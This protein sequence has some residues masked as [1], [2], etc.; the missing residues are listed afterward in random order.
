MHVCIVT[1]HSYVVCIIAIIVIIIG[2]CYVVYHVTMPEVS[3]CLVHYTKYPN[4]PPHAP[5]VTAENGSCNPIPL[6]SPSCPPFCLM[7]GASKP[8]YSFC[9][10]HPPPSFADYLPS[11]SP[12]LLFLYFP[13]TQWDLL[14]HLLHRTHQCV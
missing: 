5:R 7:G 12:H 14:H 11:L 1:A 9:S 2:Q 6:L 13:A 8:S 3:I 10:S 4:P